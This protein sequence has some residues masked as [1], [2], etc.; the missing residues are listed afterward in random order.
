MASYPHYDSI[1]PNTKNVFS[2]WNLIELQLVS[3]VFRTF[4]RLWGVAASSMPVLGPLQSGPTSLD[5]LTSPSIFSVEN[6][7][8]SE[9]STPP[10]KLYYTMLARMLDK[11]PIPLLTSGRSCSGIVKCNLPEWY[12]TGRYGER[13]LIYK[14]ISL[15]GL[16]I[17]SC[18]VSDVMQ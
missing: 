13:Y 5:F 17:V 18:E 6:P 16:G 15:E 9:T 10:A 4:H 2:R 1:P 14:L 12:T 8:T 11:T 3:S 7:S